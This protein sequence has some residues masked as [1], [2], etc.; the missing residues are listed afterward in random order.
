MIKYRDDAIWYDKIKSE[1]V[2]T[3]DIGGRDWKKE[4][5]KQFLNKKWSN[6]C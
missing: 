6:F 5:K 4:I 1:Y 3:K 2:E